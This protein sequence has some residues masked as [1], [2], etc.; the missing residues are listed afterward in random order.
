MSSLPDYEILIDE[1]KQT[2]SE[3]LAK[4]LRKHLPSLPYNQRLALM[5][6]YNIGDLGLKKKTPHAEI[7]AKMNKTKLAVKLLCHKALKRLKVLIPCILLI[8]AVTHLDSKDILTYPGVDKKEL[9]AII[10]KKYQL[11]STN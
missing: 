11:Y 7:A 4:Q 1:P 6:R 2:K 9:H 8:G 5:M 10:H 3:I